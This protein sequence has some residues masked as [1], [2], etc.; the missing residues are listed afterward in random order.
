M[1]HD[2]AL[3][4]ELG[5]ELARARERVGLTQAE[6]AARL[7]VS[8][9]VVSRT[10]SG[11]RKLENEELRRFTKELGSEEAMALENRR[12]RRWCELPRPPLKHPDHDL[13][14]KAECAGQKLAA[15][16][17]QPD[18]VHAFAR[19]IDGLLAEIKG[20]A[21]LLRKR[22]CDVV[23]IGKVGVG[24][25]S[26]ICR[27]ANLVVQRPGARSD[28]MVLD[29]GGG[30]I[31]LC[32]VQVTTGPTAIA[33]EPCSDSEIRAYVAEFAD[34]VLHGLG[35]DG[36]S[37]GIEPE[38]RSL[39]SEVERA[40]RNI[41]GLARPRGKD[42]DGNRLPDPAKELAREVLADEASRG[43][44]VKEANQRL[45]FEVLSRM[46]PDRRGRLDIHFDEG[47]GMNPLAWLKT[48]FHRINIGTNP[49]F[50][51]PKRIRVSVDQAVLPGEGAE[52][53][54]V[55]IIDTKGIDETVAR[56]DLESHFGSA[57]T[58]I[59]LCSGFNDAPGTEAVDLLD[60]AAAAG[61]EAAGLHGMLLGLPRAEEALQMRDDAGESAD[62][63]E[64]GYDLKSGVVEEVVHA[65]KGFRD[66][67][68]Q[69]F[70]AHE[71]EAGGIRAQLSDRVEAM[72]DGYRR[73]M[74]ELVDDAQKLLENFEDEQAQ[75]IVR[76]AMSMVRSWMANN[77]NAP[78]AG[79]QI[80]ESLMD[81]LNDAH[82]ST[83]HAT[84]RRRGGWYNLDYGHHLAY[85]ARL[86]VSAVLRQKVASFEE[87]CTTF[88]TDPENK[89]ARTL[90][91]QA[92]RTMAK[93]YQR[94]GR[95][96]QLLGE[97]WFHDELEPDDPLWS[98]CVR[99][100]G[101]GGG[102]VSDV[103]DLNVG[104][105][106]GHPDANERLRMMVER[107]WQMA[108]DTVEEMLE[109]E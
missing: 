92:Q 72:F 109:L 88:L 77:R 53:I 68:V 7:R 96:A 75:E 16:L 69:F 22:T 44:E 37:Q 13:L 23:F 82:P 48:E 83:I 20:A 52:G 4:R 70:N 30:R 91:E 15:H 11:A 49:E 41:A 86:A 106:S 79:Q 17:S 93:A 57:H 8:Q 73:T 103:T 21:E 19:R 59:V 38:E 5:R 42:P 63:I 9:A 89:P 60:R 90:L 12:A 99:R 28:A 74:S 94:V 97:T 1:P 61:I 98:R 24:K 56:A 108:M 31:T 85:G 76:Q 50:T 29:V 47:S 80:E 87:H 2:I 10:E 43:R 100:W 54:E 71:D 18:T 67:S 107:E 58:V 78:V 36:E 81:E 84:M 62:T 105:F 27:I 95:R 64:E 51:I 55:R 65:K 101:K 104:W 33:I 26:A 66:F 25:T 102:Y 39:A 34:K 40:I 45:Q 14:W 35:V 6:L 32:E 46:K 3:D